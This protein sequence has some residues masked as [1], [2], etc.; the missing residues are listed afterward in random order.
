M[1]RKGNVIR[2]IDGETPWKKEGSLE[3]NSLR[4]SGT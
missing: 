1:E 4:Q 3:T 2:R